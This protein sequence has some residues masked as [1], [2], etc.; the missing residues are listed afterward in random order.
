MNTLQIESNKDILTVTLNREEYRNSVNTE[1]LHELHLA[2]DQAEADT[3]CRAMVIQGK[4]EWFCTGMDFQE[5]TQNVLAGQPAGISADEYMSLLKRFSSSSRFIISKVE[6]RV[7]AG[8]VGIVAASDFVLA[9]NKAQFGLSEA[10]WGLLPANVMPFLVRRVG[11]QPAY[12]MTL[13][14]RDITAQRAYEI[15]LVDELSDNLDEALRRLMTHL[16][17]VAGT[18]VAEAKHFF[19]SMW[20]LEENME[21]TAITELQKLIAQPAVINNITNYILHKKFPWDKE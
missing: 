20:I 21:N 5:L 12:T 8:G 10:M 9:N 6:G 1:L 13:S 19:R 17:R 14:T 7:L 18:T 16:R 2:L 15:H 4:N 3:N 11:F